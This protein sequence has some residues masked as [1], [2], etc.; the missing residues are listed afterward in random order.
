MK[1]K[2]EFEQISLIN[3]TYTSINLPILLQY[4]LYNM[5]GRCFYAGWACYSY[6]GVL[7]CAVPFELYRWLEERLVP[8]LSPTVY[9]RDSKV[10]LE[11]HF[12]FF[13]V[14]MNGVHGW[15]LAEVA[16][17][18]REN[19]SMKTKVEKYNGLRERMNEIWNLAEPDADDEGSDV[20][21]GVEEQH[22]HGNAFAQQQ[23]HEHRIHDMFNN[24]SGQQQQNMEQHVH[25]NGFAQ[26]Q[27]YEFHD[28]LRNVCAQQRQEQRVH[29]NTFAQQQS[30]GKGGGKGQVFTSSLDSAFFAGQGKGKGKGQIRPPVLVRRS[31]ISPPVTQAPVYVQ[32]PP[33][34]IHR[35]A[36]PTCNHA[37]NYFTGVPSALLF[38]SHP[39]AFQYAPMD[40]QMSYSSRSSLTEEDDSFS[41]YEHHKIKID[42][43]DL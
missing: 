23:N 30:S 5:Y 28:M 10:Y 42:M 2:T 9:F 32:Q 29:Q 19:A 38:P 24:L 16:R 21:D 25:G 35:A 43:D 20:D 3:L 36:L 6:N 13:I 31:I 11:I 22:A 41:D 8:V 27:T 4:E 37:M 39:T 26:Q 15:P 1:N 14:R 17:L 12:N 33:Q 7:W 34:P 18:Q 40:D